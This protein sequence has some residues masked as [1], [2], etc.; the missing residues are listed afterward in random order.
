[1]N[2]ISKIHTQ[3]LLRIRKANL[4]ALTPSQRVQLNLCI[5]QANHLEGVPSI[6]LIG[7]APKLHRNTSSSAHSS[8]ASLVRDCQNALSFAAPLLPSLT[9]AIP[10]D[11]PSGT[12]ENPPSKR[13]KTHKILSGSSEERRQGGQKKHFQETPLKKSENNPTTS[14]GASTKTEGNYIHA[15]DSEAESYLAIAVLG[16]GISSS[17]P[18]P[19]EASP[20]MLSPSVLQFPSM[21]PASPLHSS[22][23]RRSSPS[24]S[25]QQPATIQPAAS[26]PMPA[27]SS[28][29]VPTTRCPSNDIGFSAQTLQAPLDLSLLPPYYQPEQHF[30]G[31]SANFIYNTMHPNPTPAATPSCLVGNQ[32]NGISGNDNLLNGY[33]EQ[34]FFS[35]YLNIPIEEYICGQDLYTPQLFFESGVQIGS[36]IEQLQSTTSPMYGQQMVDF[37]QQHFQE[38][39]Q[40][41]G[42]HMSYMSLT[43]HQLIPPYQFRQ[44]MQWAQHNFQAW[45]PGS[46]GD[47][48]QSPISLD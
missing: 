31:D 4:A 30:P 41:G 17:E 43:G 37:S 27:T 44:Q 1:M 8:A 45:P 38:M 35:Q 40:R 33:D 7:N 2:S 28:P 16:D 25:I 36:G 6:P 29:S 13:A 3:F 34:A 48:D 10:V 21:A 18:M 46:E 42:I 15:A 19:I 12:V 39:P 20:Q 47:S 26:V 5:S 23:S 9:A 24:S 11:F 22:G 14:I 32:D